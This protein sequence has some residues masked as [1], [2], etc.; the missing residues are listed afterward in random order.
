MK[1]FLFLLLLAGPL[2]AAERVVLEGDDDYAPYAFMENGRYTGIYIEFFK[3]VAE[4][5]APDYQL[6][7]RP[8][9]WKRGLKN[10]ENGSSFA[11]FPPYFN[12][13]RQYI[14]HY[15]S[16]IHQEN[17]VLFC[18]EEV[19]KSG[20]KKFPADFSDLHIGVNLGFTLGDKM[21]AAVRAGQVRVEEVKGNEANIKKLLAGRIDCYANDRISVLYGIKKWQ[22]KYG[23]INLKVVESAYLSAENVFIA[24]SQINKP[25]Y[26][27]D[28]IYKMNRAIEE[29]KKTG[30]MNK[31]I[32]QY[33]GKPVNSSAAG[34]P[35]PE[36]F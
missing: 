9:P 12:S 1:G 15:S 8:V 36:S 11:L 34:L 32:S 25:A 3:K 23:F 21:V 30:I 19:M 26:S 20:N 14:Q 2:P 7:L 10:I 22:E 31:M 28:F 16:S 29:V 13:D 18:R 6:E 24:Y 5:L 35:A 17:I 33:I 4:K 27:H